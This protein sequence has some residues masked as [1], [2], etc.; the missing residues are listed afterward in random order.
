MSGGSAKEK[1]MRKEASPPEV[2]ER[3]C[4]LSCSTSPLV[5]AAPFFPTPRRDLAV[6][7]MANS[8]TNV[9][10]VEPLSLNPQHISMFFVHC[11]DF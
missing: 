6:D 7:A 10:E 11:H 1:V 3:A 2:E 8:S 9:Q 4:K 5:I